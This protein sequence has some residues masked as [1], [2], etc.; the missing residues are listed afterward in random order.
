MK[1]TDKVQ[2]RM[3]PFSLLM[4][5]LLSAGL[6]VFGSGQPEKV[7]EAEAS[8]QGTAEDTVLLGGMPIGI[9]MET[10]GIMVLDTEPV[11][12]IDGQK[13]DPAAHTVQSG[14]Y[15]LKADH[16]PIKGKEELIDC[17]E[18]CG[19]EDLILTL[20]RKDEV[21]DVKLRPVEYKPDQYRLGIWVRDNVQGLGTVTYLTDESRFG[22]LGHGIHDADTSGLLSISDGTVYRTS[23]RDVVKG[24]S[25]SPGSMEGIIVYNQYNILGSIDKNTE[26][27]VY[28]TIQKIDELFDEQIP[29]QIGKKEEIVT[30]D[31]TIRC[32]VDNEIRNYKI[33]ITNID[34]SSQEINKGF[35]IEV[36]DSE[37][38]EKTGGIIQGMSGSPIVQ[39]GKL[40]GAVTHVFVK[41]STMGYGIFI[42]NMLFERNST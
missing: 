29:I 27:G 19:D 24:S 30:G 35:T 1:Q 31:A 12:G 23:I 20:R 14:D 16:C 21:F 4:I 41:N 6:F 18:R 42:E 17:I 9:Y 33:R 11:E 34:T 25:G 5:C 39:N 28:G 13:Y 37:L 40:V 2:R 36:T 10:D 26:S 15:I 7:N 3:A 32:C 22:A 38:L 8:I